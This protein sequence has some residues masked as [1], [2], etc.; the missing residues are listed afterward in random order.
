[1][2]EKKEEEEEGDDDDDELKMNCH[3]CE[4]RNIC[5]QTRFYFFFFFGAVCCTVLYRAVLRSVPQ[6]KTNSNKHVYMYYCKIK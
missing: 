5:M 3:V 2:N 4:R 6:S 1:M